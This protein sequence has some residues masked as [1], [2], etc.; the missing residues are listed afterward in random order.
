[1]SQDSMKEIVYNLFKDVQHPGA[2][3]IIDLDIL[4]VVDSVLEVMH[5]TSSFLL[6]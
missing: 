6:Q 1:M 5:N 4:L 2:V 3:C